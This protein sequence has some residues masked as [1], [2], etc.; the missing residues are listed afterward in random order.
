[1]GHPEPQQQ[2]NGVITGKRKR[3]KVKIQAE[4]TLDNVD[5]LPIENFY[6]NASIFPYW[7]TCGHFIESSSLSWYSVYYCEN[8]AHLQVNVSNDLPFLLYY[9]HIKK[10]TGVFL[11]DIKIKNL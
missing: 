4:C 7:T 3:K 9:L 8:Q 11:V 1:M 2:E 10:C 6:F 5:T